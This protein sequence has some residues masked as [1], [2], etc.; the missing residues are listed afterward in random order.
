MEKK[1]EDKLDELN[2][3]NNDINIKTN[4]DNNNTLNTENKKLCPR[5]KKNE[6]EY[7][8]LN[9]VFEEIEKNKDYVTERKQISSS[10]KPKVA[11]GAPYL[12][13]VFKDRP[14]F[15]CTCGY[16]TNQPYCDGESHEGTGFKPLKF[17]R[18]IQTSLVAICGCKYNR[19]EVS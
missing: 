4:N 1:I 18:N 2:I 7:S 5:D 10:L 9:I 12:R 17:V 11:M 15:Y 3:N 6:E 8:K 14:Y 19:S 13:H 16:S